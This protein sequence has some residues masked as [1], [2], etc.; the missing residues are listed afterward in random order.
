[1]FVYKA[2]DGSIAQVAAASGVTEKQLRAGHPD[3]TLVEVDDDDLPSNLLSEAWRFDE[4]EDII[5][6][7]EKGKSILEAL[8]GSGVGQSGID[9]CETEQDLLDMLASISS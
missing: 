1:M 4:D 3:N 9:S 7:I 5:V 2:K 8:E 6:D